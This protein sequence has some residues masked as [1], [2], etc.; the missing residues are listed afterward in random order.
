MPAGT[1]RRRLERLEAAHE[2]AASAAVVLYLPTDTD[3]ERQARAPPGARTVL[4]MPWNARDPERHPGPPPI[5][6]HSEPKRSGT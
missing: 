2:A 3:E 5:A 4:F 1:V 6:N